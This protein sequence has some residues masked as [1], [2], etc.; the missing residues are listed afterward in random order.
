MAFL[1]GARI[2][3]HEQLLFGIFSD[4]QSPAA[5]LGSGSYFTYIDYRRVVSSTY[6]LYESF[7]D[8]RNSFIP[9]LTWTSTSPN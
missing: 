1:G 2:P 8:S 7:I 4:D 6:L 3:T 5:M 9:L